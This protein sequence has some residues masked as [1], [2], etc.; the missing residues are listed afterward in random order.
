MAL[1]DEESLKIERKAERLFLIAKEDRPIHFLDEELSRL[2]EAKEF[3]NNW[4]FPAPNFDG[5]S[6]SPKV[7][8][9]YKYLELVFEKPTNA[10]CII[11]VSR[12][13]TARLLVVLLSQIGTP[14]LRLGSLVG[15][16]YGDPGDV[17]ISFRQQVLTLNKFRKGEI[18][19]LVSV[20][21]FLMW[22]LI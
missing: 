13:Y 4:T 16:R 3:V 14:N 21:G 11:F 18:N 22:C 5:N 8:L 6:L 9:L 2:R 1:E 19:C 7:L 12:R 15:T 20:P 10:R 17:K